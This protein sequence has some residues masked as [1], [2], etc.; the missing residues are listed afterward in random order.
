MA[1]KKRTPHRANEMLEVVYACKESEK[2]LALFTTNFRGKIARRNL[3][4]AEKL[5]NRTEFFSSEYFPLPAYFFRRN[6]ENSR[7]NFFSTENLGSYLFS[8]LIEI[9]ILCKYSRPHINFIRFSL[10]FDIFRNYFSSYMSL[11]L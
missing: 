6:P 4:S 7:R 5:K 1:K 11:C 10:N 8:W 2:S 9:S 3:F